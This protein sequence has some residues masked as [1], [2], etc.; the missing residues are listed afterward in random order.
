LV[1]ASTRSRLY[2]ALRQVRLT[3]VPGTR[4]AYSNAA[5]QLAGEILERVEGMPFEALVRLRI[6]APLGMRDTFVVPTQPQKARLV[7]G[8]EAAVPQ[9]YFP[10]QMPA[11]GALKSTLADMLA[12]ARWQLA[13]R[14]PA[15]RLSHHPLD[16]DGR[17]VA[18]LN[19]QIVMD[20]ARRVIFQDGSHPG[21]ASLLVLHP[22]SGMAVVLLSNE[23]DRD[24]MGRLRLLANGIA[25]ALDAGSMAVP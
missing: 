9:P 19:W 25:Q 7:S 15:V 24:T 16:H 14:D 5:A 12:Y 8:Y 11:A 20:G 18:G 21:F 3:A 10:D 1:A 4:F 13:E 22:G 23:I 2:A 6:A 17:Y